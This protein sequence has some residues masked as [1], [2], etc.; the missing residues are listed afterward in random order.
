MCF[1][2]ERRSINIYIT[3]FVSNLQFGFFYQ[4]VSFYQLLHGPHRT[5][6]HSSQFMLVLFF[7]L[8]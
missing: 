6:V 4:N 1:S 3:L 8:S 7:N 2:T 5:A